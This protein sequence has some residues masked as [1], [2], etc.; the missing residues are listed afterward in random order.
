VLKRDG[1]NWERKVGFVSGKRW[2][3]DVW[4]VLGKGK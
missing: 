1:D 3:G 2:I 4:I